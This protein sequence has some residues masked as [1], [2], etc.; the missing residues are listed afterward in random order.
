MLIRTDVIRLNIGK[1]PD[2][3]RKSRRPLHHD[4]LGGHLHHHTGTAGICHFPEILLNQIRF[5]CGVHGRD[6]LL[7]DDRLDRSDQSHLI[8]C[9]FQN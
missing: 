2:L 7:P 4:G 3:E 1:N 9:I 8:A 5:R 6:F